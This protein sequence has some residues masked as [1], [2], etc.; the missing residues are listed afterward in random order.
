MILAQ[1]NPLNAF[2]RYIIVSKPRGVFLN[3]E[4]FAPDF[5]TIMYH[6]TALI[7]NTMTINEVCLKSY[8]FSVGAGESTIVGYTGS[9]N[10]DIPCHIVDLTIKC[11]LK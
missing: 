9:S 3:T 1:T 10:E 7:Q 11:L 6:I 2:T 8:S 5:F 4:Q